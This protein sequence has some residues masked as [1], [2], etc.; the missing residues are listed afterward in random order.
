VT[1]GGDSGNRIFVLYWRCSLIRGSTVLVTCMF[2]YNGHVGKCPEKSVATNQSLSEAFR[3]SL[4]CMQ[5]SLISLTFSNLRWVGDR[6]MTRKRETSGQTWCVCDKPP[7][8]T[9]LWTTHSHI[10]S[11]HH[12]R[13]QGTTC[14]HGNC[15]V[16][17][18]VDCSESIW[19]TP[20]RYNVM[21][22]V[23]VH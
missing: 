9:H 2:F 5:Q 8:R 13:C 11:L 18:V 17:L 4:N 23:V 15:K 10:Q 1:Y 3:K 22:T 19:E 7:G 14:H 21:W 12:H 16:A 6:A 20:G